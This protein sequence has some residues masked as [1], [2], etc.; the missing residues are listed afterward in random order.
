MSKMRLSN[1]VAA[2]V[3]VA[4]LAGCNRPP[5]V[6]SPSVRGVG[7]VRIDDVVKKHPLYG[8]LAQLDDAMIALQL[9]SL[10]PAV[11]RTGAQIATETRKLNAELR[12]AQ[13]RAN[14]TLRQK[15]QDFQQREQA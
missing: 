15:Q 8:Q 12:A 1:A 9:Q 6:N 14:A 13:D 10:G 2:A 7:Y 3:M 11:P 5:D 4:A